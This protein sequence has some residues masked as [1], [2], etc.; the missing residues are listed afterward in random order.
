MSKICSLIIYSCRDQDSVTGSQLPKTT[1]AAAQLMGWAQATVAPTNPDEADS[2]IR[3]HAAD[4]IFAV[5]VASARNTAYTDWT[6]L[7]TAASA[8]ATGTSVQATPTSN[9]TT[10][11]SAP[12]NAT[13]TTASCAENRVSS[14]TT[15]DYIIV[16]AGAG[17]IPLADKLSENGASVLLIEKGPPSSGRWGGTMKPEWLE[18]TNLTRFDVPG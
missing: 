18:G 3:Q 9:S 15:Y 1:S 11:T 2:G 16:G 8:T 4:G 6:S 13:A 14:N 7:A 10:P 17:G 12:S 5:T